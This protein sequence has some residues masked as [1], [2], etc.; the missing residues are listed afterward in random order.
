MKKLFG[1][2]FLAAL[3][4]LVMV[5]ALAV[6]AVATA[7]PEGSAAKAN[8]SVTVT[9]VDADAKLGKANKAD[10]TDK[11]RRFLLGGNGLAIADK[12]RTLFGELGV[13]GSGNGFVILCHRLP[14]A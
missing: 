8:R 1:K 14:R 9:K 13:G 4:S 7:L 12:T 10:L 11:V 2:R 5:A 6:S 3:L